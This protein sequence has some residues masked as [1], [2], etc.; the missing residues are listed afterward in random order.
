M[1]SE[2][3]VNEVVLRYC[4]RRIDRQL[5]KIDLSDT[6]TIEGLNELYNQKTDSL[7]IENIAQVAISKIEQAVNDKN[8]ELLLSIYDNKGL[9][10][11]AATHL[12]NCRRSDFENWLVRVLRNNKVQG[13]SDSIQEILPVINPQ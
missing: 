6:D 13:L 5:K 7:N 10:A 9:I 8:L 4:R 1:S 2:S 3:V 12:K 11:L